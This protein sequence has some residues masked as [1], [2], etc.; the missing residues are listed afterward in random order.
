MPVNIL[1]NVELNIGRNVYLYPMRDQRL[2]TATPPSSDIIIQK[3]RKNCE[4]II[5]FCAESQEDVLFYKFEKALTP[6]IYEFA[7]LCIELFLMRHHEQFS[8]ASWI[9]AGFYAQPSPIS[10]TLKTTFGC[11]KY[12]RTYLCN[13]GKSAGGFYPLDGVLGITS[14][15]FSAVVI[16]L[17]CKLSTRMSFRSSKL[18]FSSFFGWSPST[19]AIEH[20]VLGA[21][22][23]G[24]AYM[25][26]VPP[27]EGD[28]EI[29]V[30]EM[31][32]KATPTATEEELEKRRGPRE[33]KSCDCSCQRHRGK[34]TR[35]NRKRKR[36][37]RGDKSKN[38]RSTTLVVMYTLKADSDGRLH[39]PLNKVIW[40]SYACRRVMV[41]WARRQATKRGFPLET[42]KQIHIVVDGEVC[43]REQ[44]SRLFP[45]AT[46]S[47]DIR[48]LEEK[49]WK[50]GRTFEK[51]G[52][53]ELDQWVESKRTLL[54]EGRAK[55]LLEQLK[56][57]RKSLSRRAKRDDAKRN[58]LMALINYM[59]KRLDMMK[60]KEYVEKDLPIASGIVEGAARYVVGERLDCAGMRWIP[61]RAE[62]L[63]HLRCIELNGDW[64][65][66]FQWAYDGWVEKL[67]Q[68]KKVLIR[69]NQPI[70]L[71][72][73]S[74]YTST[75]SRNV[76]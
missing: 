27:P 68:S 73:S 24:S 25:E 32:G 70:D 35:Q 47:L 51:E 17:C 41:S 60:Y 15:G 34:A 65:R 59:E 13:K 10:R 56:E 29:L 66:F 54:Y 33:K 12:W 16:S 69:T 7:C 30:I 6:R 19:E 28:G 3:I 71:L 72:S 38:G 23:L 39:G 63:L 43:L 50:V 76:A 48:H 26:I 9:K 36:R 31:D 61:G 42:S 52:S 62:A 57:L 37:K 22:R 5:S 45:K 4:E 18:I 74:N 20:F 64:D 21:G 14:D 53:D 67:R 2:N 44:L 75:Q 1:Y 49:V 40:G 55:E 46:F 8:C 11:V 58:A